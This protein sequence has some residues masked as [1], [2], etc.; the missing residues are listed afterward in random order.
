MNPAGG[1]CHSFIVWG[2]ISAHEKSESYFIASRVEVNADHYVQSI[3]KP[4]IKKGL[5]ELFYIQMETYLPTRLWSKQENLETSA[6]SD[7][8]YL[9][10]EHWLTNSP[11]TSLMDYGAWPY[12]GRLVNDRNPPTLQGFKKF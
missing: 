7:S 10:L 2:A 12:L 5:L 3:M 11:D 1:M 6:N 8:S 9:S 4:F